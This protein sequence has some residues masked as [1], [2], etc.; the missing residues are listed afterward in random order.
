MGA[1]FA[2]SCGKIV[3]VLIEHFLWYI[4]QCTN[5]WIPLGELAPSSHSS[6]RVF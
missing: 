2:D 5:G 4:A 3:Q 6:R 1:P